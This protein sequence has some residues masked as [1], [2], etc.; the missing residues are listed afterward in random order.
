MT[1]QSF[2]AKKLRLLTGVLILEVRVW[3]PGS[4]PQVRVG[5]ERG[6]QQGQGMAQASL[7]SALAGRLHSE[8]SAGKAWLCRASTVASVWPSSVLVVKGQASLT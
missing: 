5:E 8:V 6:R 4:S 3:G 7:L 2:R 1:V